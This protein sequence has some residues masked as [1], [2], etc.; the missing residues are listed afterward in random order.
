MLFMGTVAH[1]KL[2]N[3]S[4]HRHTNDVCTFVGIVITIA[5]TMVVNLFMKL[6]ELKEKGSILCQRPLNRLSATDHSLNLD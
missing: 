1:L 5:L 3:K 6:C 2:R 4:R